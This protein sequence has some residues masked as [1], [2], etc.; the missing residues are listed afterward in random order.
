MMM[1]RRQCKAAGAAAGHEHEE[2]LIANAKALE[3][4][5]KDLREQ[6]SLSGQGTDNPILDSKFQGSNVAYTIYAG[7][8]VAV[9]MGCV[10]IEA[11][12]LPDAQDL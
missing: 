11:E 4:M 7:D 3:N 1:R 6:H 12:D 8:S 9:P 5:V 2:A 10:Y